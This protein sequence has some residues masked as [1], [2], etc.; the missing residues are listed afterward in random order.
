MFSTAPLI[1]IVPLM[2]ETVLHLQNNSYKAIIIKCSLELNA[3]RL[4]S[5]LYTFKYLF[6]NFCFLRNR[7]EDLK[8][9]VVHNSNHFVLKI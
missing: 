2:W 6:R 9:Q 3:A 5:S 1:C 4:F 7:E 8:M